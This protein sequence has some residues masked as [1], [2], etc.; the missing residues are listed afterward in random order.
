MRAFFLAAMTIGASIWTAE[1][2]RRDSPG[3]L[4]VPNLI[5]DFFYWGV[6]INCLKGVD[7]RAPPYADDVALGPK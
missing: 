6:M 2:P 4:F 3:K 1:L 7:I 5:F